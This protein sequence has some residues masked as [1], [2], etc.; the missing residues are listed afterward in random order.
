MTNSTIIYENHKNQQ[1]TNSIEL[2]HGPDPL[3]TTLLILPNLNTQ[4]PPLRRQYSVHF[5][6]EP[7]ILNTSAQSSRNKKNIQ[8]T[9]QQLVN[10]VRQFN[11]QNNQQMLQHRILYKQRQHKHY[12]RFLEE[13]HNYYISI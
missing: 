1:P 2:T 12:H 8:L 6:T 5:P 3:N 9:P 4:L 7:V 13:I 10:F 11:S